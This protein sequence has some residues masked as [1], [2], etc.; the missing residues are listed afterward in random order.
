MGLPDFQ[1]QLHRLAGRAFPL[2]GGQRPHPAPRSASAGHL[3]LCRAPLLLEPGR[4]L[5]LLC[6]Q[7]TGQAAAQFL[8]GLPELPFLARGETLPR[9]PPS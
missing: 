4:G 7:L 2:S 1:R 5:H 9:R 3:I 8:A 6:L